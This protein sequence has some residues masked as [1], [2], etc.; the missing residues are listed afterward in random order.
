MARGAAVEV[1]ADPAAALVAV[2]AGEALAVAEA[3]DPARAAATRR[4]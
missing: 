2:S 1:V 4:R 3:R